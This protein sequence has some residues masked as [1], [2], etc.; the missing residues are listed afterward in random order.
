LLD[1]IRLHGTSIARGLAL[2]EIGPAVL[3]PVRL[4]HPPK[5]RLAAGWEGAVLHV[6]R[7]GNLTTN[8]LEADLAALGG[9]DLEG[10]EVTMGPSTLPLV[11]AYSDV[12]P[13]VACA[14]VSSSGRLEIAVHGGRADSL[15][16]AGREARVVV[17]RRVS[18]VLHSPSR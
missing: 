5:L 11:R 7:F 4:A 16:G 10:L 12:A 15:P 2:E 8:L 9:R 3:D 14:L 1:R 17:R 13:G 18:S 6:D